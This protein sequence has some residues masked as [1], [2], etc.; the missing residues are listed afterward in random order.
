MV[1]KLINGQLLPSV[2]QVWICEGKEFTQEKRD[3]DAD[4]AD[5]CS[6]DSQW[7]N[8]NVPHS[9]LSGTDH[10]FLLDH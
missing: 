4:G 7:D 9:L 1:M 10:N 5:D 8:F 6:C 2:S 3:N